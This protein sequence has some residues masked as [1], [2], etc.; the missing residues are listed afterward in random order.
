MAQIKKLLEGLGGEGV[1]VRSL[2]EY[3]SNAGAYV[4]L[5]CSRRRGTI[6]LPAQLIGVNKMKDEAKEAYAK[7]VSL[8]NLC[9]I[10]AEYEAKLA[11]VESAIR[12]KLDRMTVSNGFMLLRRYDAFKA[13]FQQAKDDYF[14]E[15]DRIL[16]DWD[17]LVKNFTVAMDAVLAESKLLKRDKLRLRK[18]L[19]DRI[20]SKDVYAS[21]FQMSLT[22]KVLPAMPDVSNIPKNVGNDV[23]AS[24]KETVIDNAVDCIATLIQDAFNLC[25]GVAAKYAI[26]GDIN[27]NSI[28]G[29]VS[30]GQRIK[31]NNV[32]RN[33][34]LT[35]SANLLTSI[36][37][38][39]PELADE[40]EEVVEQVLVDLYQYSIETGLELT[41]PKKGLSK[42]NLNTMVE[43]KKML[44]Q[45]TA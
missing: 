13:E 33:P 5:S 31:E 32:F 17:Q 8:G 41:L 9:F 15:R 44:S 26:R 22:V 24:W 34:I 14:A 16:N 23:L 21:S 11:K 7:Y 39:S 42:E 29:L 20:P 12:Y 38:I 40:Q 45:Q 30:M 19:L 27:G 18:E 1:T 10:P 6:P 35:E 4:T 28:N 25:S 43:L 3:M 37:D 36:K 2:A